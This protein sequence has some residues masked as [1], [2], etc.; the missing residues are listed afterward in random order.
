ML[1]TLRRN[2][3]VGCYAEVTLESVLQIKHYSGSPTKPLEPGT[4]LET[5]ANSPATARTTLEPEPEPK[6]L[7]IVSRGNTNPEDI[8]KSDSPPQNDDPA[9]GLLR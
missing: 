1:K 3:K 9:R 4:L 6:S 7:M 2:T 8:C 5:T